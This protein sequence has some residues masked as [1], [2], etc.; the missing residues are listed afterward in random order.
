MT[1]AK[2]AS[3]LGLGPDATDWQITEGIRNLREQ[4]DTYR[5]LAEREPFG[6]RPTRWEVVPE[7]AVVA[8]EAE[9]YTVERRETWEGRRVQITLRQGGKV[10]RP[11]LYGFDDVVD[12]LTPTGEQA[13]Q[14]LLRVELAARM[15]SPEDHADREPLDTT[16][17]A[18]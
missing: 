14:R 4:R 3:L 7:G 18:S 10:Y 1:N 11:K 5:E 8:H 9:A 12:V 17:L 13:V 2:A 6:L 16:K 15:L